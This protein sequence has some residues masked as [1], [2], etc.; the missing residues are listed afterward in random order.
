MGDPFVVSYFLFINSLSQTFTLLALSEGLMMV[1][2]VDFKFDT[3]LQITPLKCS[4]KCV[5]KSLIF[6]HGYLFFNSDRSV[7]VMVKASMHPILDPIT[8]FTLPV[9]S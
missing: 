9:S 1:D 5:C 6:L 7:S 8:H 3:F 4:S 2:I